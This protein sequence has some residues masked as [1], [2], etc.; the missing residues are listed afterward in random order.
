MDGKCD[1]DTT[2]AQTTPMASQHRRDV[3]SRPA[4]VSG[5]SH[6]PPKCTRCPLPSPTNQHE[7][8]QGSSFPRAEK[9]NRSR[10]IVD[11]VERGQTRSSSTSEI[12]SL[13]LGWDLLDGWACDG[14]LRGVRGLAKVWA[15][16]NLRVERNTGDGV[17]TRPV[18]FI[19]TEYIHRTYR[20]PVPP[21]LPST[22]QL[23]LQLAVHSYGERRTVRVICTNQSLQ[24]G[25]SVRVFTDSLV[26]GF[27]DENYQEDRL[28]LHNWPTPDYPLPCVSL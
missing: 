6:S 23:A 1:T 17:G 20:V 25:Q 8:R 26:N 19:D 9:K 3:P 5:T 10:L 16:R 7:R 27:P 18:P 15:V 28:P 2:Q 12:S 13:E 4:R 22:V 11:G 24:P 21:V 14:G